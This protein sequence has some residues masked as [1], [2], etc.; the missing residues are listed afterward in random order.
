MTKTLFII[1]A[2]GKIQSLESILQKIGLD[3]KVQATSGHLYESPSELSDL[4]IDAQFRETKRRARKDKTIWWMRKEAREA[5]QIIIATDADTEGDVIAWDVYELLKDLHPEML[6]V[7][8]KGMDPESVEASLSD[9]YPVRKTDAVPGRT[10]AIVDRMIGHTFSKNGIGIGRVSTGLLGLLNQAGD[11][12]STTRLRLVAPAKDGQQPWVAHCDCGRVITAVI[13]EKLAALT[14]PAL[15]M[16]ASKPTD[17]KLMNMGDI[18]VRSGDDLGMKPKETAASLQKMYETG[19]MSYPR[20]GS[21]GVSKGAQRR[22]A[23]MIKKS[24]FRGK[25]EILQEK[26]GEDTHDAP[27]PIGDVDVSKD[28]RKLGDDHGVRTLVA[29]EF[30]KSSIQREKQAAFAKPI[31]QFLKQQGFSE[32]VALHVAKLPWTR[33]IGPRF[34]GKRSHPAHAGNRALGES[35][36]G[37]PWPPQ[38]M[39]QTHRRLHGARPG[40]REPAAH[41]EGQGVGCGR[42][43][44]T[45]RPA[46][47]AG[48]R[49]RLRTYHRRHDG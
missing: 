1:E 41:R 16:R 22:L 19:Q 10:R 18:M 26:G 35:H 13:A 24:G 49:R 27:Y 29:R 21:R 42:P 45:P 9:A 48:D 2:P 3:A 5:E 34:P 12:I 39:G 4:G 37:R 38:H 30:V 23:R 8:L 25:S 17:G 32:E 14:L 46:R 6:R 36:A 11:D 31:F 15:D 44:G 33:E 47:L 7:K 40:R 20:S 28:P 43:S